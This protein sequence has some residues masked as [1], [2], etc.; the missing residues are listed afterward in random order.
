VVEFAVLALGCGPVFPSILRIK[1]IGVFFA[2]ERSLGAL[3]LFKIVEV[4]QEQQP[5]R[6]LGVIEF[7]GATRLFPK[8]V[9]DVS[10]SLFKHS[11]ME[12]KLLIIPQKPRG[13]ITLPILSR[14][15]KSRKN[16]APADFIFS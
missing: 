15:P 5:R 10:E 4:F 2:F 16:R 8:D 13:G 9:I 3:V 7:T 1:N 12:G 6:L 14:I 11:D